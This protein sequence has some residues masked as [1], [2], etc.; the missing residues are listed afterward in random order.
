[1]T[2]A[3]GLHE[4]VDVVDQIRDRPLTLVHDERQRHQ[5]HDAVALG[6]RPELVVAEIARV[7]V[8]RAAERVTGEHRPVPRALEHL[9][10]RALVGVGEIEGDREPGHAVD[11]LPAD[12]AEPAGGALGRAV[13]E[14]VAAVPGQ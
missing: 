12:P 7:V 11:E 6:Q 8:H 3:D 5:P 9:E 13:G 14:R 2:D 4:V 1:M 10:E